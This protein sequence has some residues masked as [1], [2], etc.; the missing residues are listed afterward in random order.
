M[1]RML[2]RN[3]GFTYMAVLFMTAIMGT[4]LAAMGTIWS[5]AQQR[6]KERELLFIGSEFRK[7]IGTYYERT[8]GT[9]KRYPTSLKDLLKDN[10]QLS[11]VRHLRRIYIDPMT[12]K[13]E[14]G[15]VKAADGGVMGIYSQSELTPFKKNNFSAL[16]ES[17]TKAE[18][19][20]QWRF[21]YEPLTT[22]LP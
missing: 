8:P 17:F 15:L 9:M 19:Y 16:D 22:K 5:T 18:K 12:L 7:A 21:V 4:V 6:E 20:S 1:V 13:A 10:R 11:T 14:W 3:Q 2:Q